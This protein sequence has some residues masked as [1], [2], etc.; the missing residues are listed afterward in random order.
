MNYSEYFSRRDRDLPA[1][2]FT[3]G[4]RVFAKFEKV[5]VAGTVLREQSNQVLIHLDLPIQTKQVVHNVVWVP[6]NDVRKMKELV[7]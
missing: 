2:K 3:H 6:T 5:P 7:I 1:P 4:S